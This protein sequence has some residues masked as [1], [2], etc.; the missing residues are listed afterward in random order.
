MLQRR[1]F[2]TVTSIQRRVQPGMIF[3]LENTASRALSVATNLPAY[4]KVF[5]FLVIRLT[6]VP[7][8]ITVCKSRK[9]G[10]GFDNDQ[11]I[12]KAIFSNHAFACRQ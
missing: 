7:S 9:V 11:Q 12:A 3:F 1:R 4:H 8:F 5:R 6:F 10:I 2:T